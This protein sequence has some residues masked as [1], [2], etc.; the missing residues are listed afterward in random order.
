VDYGADTGPIIL[1]SVVPVAQD[2]TVETLSARIQKAEHQTF[3]E[4]IKLFVEGKIRVDGRRVLIS[5]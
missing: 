4:A 1:Q 2:D 3:A 5:A